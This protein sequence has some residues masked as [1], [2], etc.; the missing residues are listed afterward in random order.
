MLTFFQYP[1]SHWCVKV[2][3]IMDYK[4]IKYNTATVGYH[5]KRELIKATGQDYVPALVNGK[6]V[7]TYAQ[8]PDYLE[9]MTPDPTIY[10]NNTKALSK[11]IEDWAHYRLEEVV[12]RY[13]VPDFPKTFK[14]DLER[15]IFVEIQE[16]KRG[17]LGLVEQKRPSLKADMNAHLQI[18]EDMLND[19]DYLLDTRPSLADFAVY[20]AV[21]P[22]P[23][24]GNKFPE[25]FVK[26]R[27]WFK[28]IQEM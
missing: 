19:H 15:W 11:A 28:S 7:I 18:I 4:G 1:Y 22:L 12:W 13:A 2:Q 24:S 9:I 27:A 8:I 16:L 17:P 20:G 25:E 26:L 21:N 3:K 10:P 23:Y 14:D 5:D 6:E